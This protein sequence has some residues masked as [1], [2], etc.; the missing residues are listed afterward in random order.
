[1]MAPSLHLTS[2]ACLG[3]KKN[4]HGPM[5]LTS[6]IILSLLVLRV[7]RDG[8]TLALIRQ[9]P[10]LMRAWPWIEEQLGFMFLVGSLD[11]SVSPASG[12]R[13]D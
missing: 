7:G 13:K 11:F 2:E 9:I 3:S 6:L 10:Y 4:G 12:K 5:G 8:H 1:M